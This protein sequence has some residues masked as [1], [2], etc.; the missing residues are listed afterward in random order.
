MCTAPYYHY[1]CGLIS[2]GPKIACETPSVLGHYTHLVTVSHPA[3]CPT[4]DGRFFASQYRSIEA[5]KASPLVSAV[6]LPPFF[7]P[8]FVA[9][10]SAPAP[11]YS[12]SHITPHLAE[13]FTPYPSPHTN[14][15]IPPGNVPAWIPREV[16]NEAIH[17]VVTPVEHF[18]GSDIGMN[19]VRGYNPIYGFDTSFKG[20][21][22][23]NGGWNPIHGSDNGPSLPFV[24]SGGWSS[25]HG[26]DDGPP[27]PGFA[28]VVGSIS[29]PGNLN[30]PTDVEAVI[31]SSP[32]ADNASVEED[33]RASNNVKSGSGE[34]PSASN[35]MQVKEP[36]VECT[37]IPPSPNNPERKSSNS[38]KPNLRKE[39]NPIFC[40][41]LPAH[42]MVVRDLRSPRSP[43]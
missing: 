15:A 24:G 4:C 22:A 43:E 19:N 33:R 8:C 2:F 3:I 30:S 12:S 26:F 20:P 5:F 39:R 21:G 1:P 6:P 23:S 41:I 31:Q 25:A 38:S 34:G 10:S 29:I 13:Q 11:S 28:P 16:R 17:S 18:R 27:P 7:T 9:C 32:A 14:A 36:T 37:P 42:M 40:A 35:Y